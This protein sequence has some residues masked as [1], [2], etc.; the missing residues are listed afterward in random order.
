MNSQAAIVNLKATI[1]IYLISLT[2][3]WVENRT[4]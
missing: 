1:Q 3:L 4:F 2:V